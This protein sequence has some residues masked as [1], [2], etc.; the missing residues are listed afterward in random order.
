[1]DVTQKKPTF[2]GKLRNSRG[3][4]LVEM[5]I[6][7]VIIGVII[8]AIVK[9][10]DLIVNSQAKQL[11]SAVSTW[12]NLT[13][14]FYDRNGRMPGDEGK[15]GIIGDTTAGVTEQTAANSAIAEITATMQNAP[16]NPVVV[17]SS[18][19]WVYIGSTTTTNS[20]DRNAILVC[21]NAL[22]SA[23]FTSD[24]L[25]MIK[26]LDTAFDGS[27][28]AGLGQFRSVTATPTF[29]PA[30]IGAAN[31]RAAT[32][33][34]TTG[35]VPDTNTTVGAATPWPATAQGAIWLFDKPF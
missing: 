11:T 22:C 12:R 19:F 28:D 15:N 2:I 18:S 8:A 33:F 30:V 23:A 16:A 27:A 3:F 31:G 1:M 9:G 32:T 24:Q 6:V 4:S 10:Q 13:M 21:G 35:V 14:A 29:I 7:M 25:E 20:G 26:A 34:S 5:A 17:G